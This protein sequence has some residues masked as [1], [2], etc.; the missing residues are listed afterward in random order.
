[1]K[2]QIL[3]AAVAVS[4]VA[5]VAFAQRGRQTRVI[6]ANEIHKGY[7]TVEGAVTY[8]GPLYF[9]G[10]VTFRNTTA[11]ATIFTDTSAATASTTVPTFQIVPTA[12]LAANDLIFAIKDVAGGSNMFS[13][14]IEGDV[15]GVKGTFSG[16]VAGT[17]GA[18]SGAVSGTTITGSGAVAGTTITGSAGVQG[19]T[20][21][22]T[23]TTTAGSITLDGAS[24]AVGTATVVAGTICV[25]S[26]TLTA[27]LIK[28]A[29]SSTT[30]TATG[31][32]AS[33][34]VINYHCL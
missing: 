22:A 6:D 23:S 7:L 3:L 27:E 13:V 32:N 8:D 12:T 29:L 2:R 15:V 33:I 20:L 21:K 16:A 28:C 1:M 17:T 18:F 5:A 25:C 9:D 31:P 30:L 14:D 4:L 19:T 26:V 24:P 10:G 34:N 11:P